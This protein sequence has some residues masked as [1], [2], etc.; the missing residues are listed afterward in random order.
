L[1]SDV[2]EIMDFD[3]FDSIQREF[4][5]IRSRIQAFAL[6]LDFRDHRQLG[7]HLPSKIP[8][9]IDR[10]QDLINPVTISK[11]C[12]DLIY[13]TQQ[14]TNEISKLMSLHSHLADCV[15]LVRTHGDIVQKRR[16]AQIDLK[17]LE[18]EEAERQRRR[19]EEDAVAMAT[20]ASLEETAGV[21]KRK[22]RRS[23]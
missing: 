20:R 15:Y 14:L 23:D 1:V 19:E 18:T 12:G 9:D 8:K 7:E 13:K 10:L 17:R 21:S 4:S 11:K 3:R 22:R 5:F 2:P 16:Q 6:R